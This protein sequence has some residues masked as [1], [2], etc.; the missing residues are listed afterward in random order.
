MVET[1]ITA[2]QLILRL[3]KLSDLES[4]HRL[5]SLAETDEYNALGIPKN[6][7]ETKS[8]HRSLDRGNQAAQ[9]KELHLY[10]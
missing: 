5:H 10:H 1:R 2:L 8:I 3:I 9:N 4:I 7:Q 6:I